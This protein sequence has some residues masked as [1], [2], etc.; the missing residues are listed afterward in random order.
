VSPSRPAPRRVP[1]VSAAGWCPACCRAQI[2]LNLLPL[3]SSWRG[4]GYKD[5]PCYNSRAHAPPS[6]P[7]LVRAAATPPLERQ[8]RASASS[9]VRRRPTTLSSFLDH[10]ESH[11]AACCLAPPLR[12]LNTKPPRPTP[13]GS[14]THPCRRTPTPNSARGSTLGELARLPTHF[15]RQKRRRSRR[16]PAS[17][18]GHLL[19]DPIATVWL[20]PGAMLRTKGIYVRTGKL[21]GAWLKTRILISVAVLLKLRKF[22]ENCR[23]IRK[24]QT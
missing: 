23:K 14:T 13:P 16:I 3:A 2:P 19:E 10:I 22:I 20:F 1:A 4:A 24:M 7:P 21:P 11:T 9:R 6:L 17:R 18:A 15:P 12:S 5:V 8:R